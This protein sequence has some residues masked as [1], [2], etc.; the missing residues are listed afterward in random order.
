MTTFSGLVKRGLCLTLGCLLLGACATWQPALQPT[1]SPNDENSYRYL[2]LDNGLR[3]LLVSDPDADKAAASLDVNVGSG[4]S[5]RDRE[6]LP[7]FLEHMLFL[8]TEKYPDSSE[9]ERYISEHGGSRNAY[10]SYAHTNYF[11]D[12]DHAHLEPALD[13]FAQFFTAPLFDEGYVER[14]K[15]AVD[16]EYQM[17]IK[18]DA[19]RNLDVFR[20]IFNPAHPMTRFSVGN[21]D[22]LADREQ[23]TVRD[24][25]LAFY[26]R[27]YSANIMT[28]SVIGRESLDELEAIITPRFSSI[29]N[30]DVELETIAEPLFAPGTLPLRVSIEPE[31][32]VRQLQ[33]FYPIPDYRDAYQ[34]KPETYLGSILGHEGEGSLLSILKADGLADSLGAGAGLSY[35]GGALISISI[36]LTQLGFE[37]RELVLSRLFQAIELVRREGPRRDLYEEQGH[38]GAQAFRF[39][40][41]VAPASYVRGLASSMQYYAPQD[42]LRGDYMMS[43]YRPELLV[44]LLD[45]MQPE[46]A[47]IV[48]VAK[49]LDTNLQSSYYQTPY[50][51][52]NLDAGQIAV[53]TE[54]EPD[55]RLTMPAPNEFIATDLE[56]RPRAVDQSAVPVLVVDEPALDI[57]YRQDDVFDVPRGGLYVNLRAPSAA[58]SKRAQNLSQ[59]YVRMVFDAV[60]EFVYPAS[61]A[62]LSASFSSHARGF[63]FSVTGYNDKQFVLLERVLKQI[64]AGDFNAQRFPDIRERL[65]RDL[66]NSKK[67]RAYTQLLDDSRE[68]FEHHEW[69]EADLAAVAETLTLEDVMGF[70]RQ[71]WSEAS[72]EA[73]VYG[74]YSRADV[75]RLRGLLADMLPVDDAPAVPR[76]EVMK[77]MAGQRY[78][79]AD[80]VD[81]ED[82]VVLQY[83][84]GADNS[85]R[86][87]ALASLTGQILQSDF[88]EEVRT[89]KQRG[90]I[91]FASPYSMRDVP[92]TVFVVQSASTDPLQLVA[93][94]EAFIMG[95]AAPGRIT[96]EVYNRHRDALILDLEQNPKNLFE[97]AGRYWRDITRQ[98]Y[99]FDSRENLIAAI[100]AIDLDEWLAYFRTSHIDNPRSVLLYTA[101]RFA[102]D[103]QTR[104]LS[105][106]LESVSDYEALKASLPSYLLH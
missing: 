66:A 77:L 78:V 44:E 101:G 62:G 105:S 32:D 39:R 85:W 73:L 20:E 65:L 45:H 13:R 94:V 50:R 69:D 81:H 89:D 86:E 64:K 91:V 31:A 15:H 106:G 41:E 18:G 93:D 82:A 35:R 48:E 30:R 9:Y 68:L 72:A 54:A 104:Q 14:E 6:G 83:F 84:Q 38:L 21:L 33:V 2:T 36:G 23:A 90:Y 61:L 52:H 56:L 37:Q 80:N 8:G 4:D 102:S 34:S 3:V 79:Y 11:F 42:V 5:P 51:R 25:L 103:E 24:D 17:G 19:R 100:K 46:K 49:G 43:D 96:T 76:L 1:K 53:L 40:G 58:G 47:F 10:T 28:L 60:N 97:Q 98:R 22:T 16:S 95:M 57:W 12:I 70:H 75:T 63:S 55:P 87:R 26:E 92:G 27:W 29:P 59:L 67:A 71:F 7:H 88:F 74:N 99:Q